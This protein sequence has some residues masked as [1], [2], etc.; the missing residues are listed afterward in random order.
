WGTPVSDAGWAN[1]GRCLP[2]CVGGSQAARRPAS[3]PPKEYSGRCPRAGGHG[4]I[5]LGAATFPRS[6]VPCATVA[7]HY[8]TATAHTGP[9]QAL[10]SR[11]PADTTYVPGYRRASSRV[12]RALCGYDVLRSRWP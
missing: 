4:H 11:P 12:L 6:R 1:K 2:R 8:K 7:G 9:G 3:T 10:V 5:A